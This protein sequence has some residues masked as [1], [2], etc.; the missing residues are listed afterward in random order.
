LHLNNLSDMICRSDPHILKHQ[1]IGIGQA[2]AVFSFDIPK[3]M[4]DAIAA[5]PKELNAIHGRIV[6]CAVAL[7][8]FIKAIDDL[9]F[10]FAPPPTS[11]RFIEA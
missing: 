2:R 7:F 1:R 11:H 5:Y 4:A 9:L 6:N 3:Q 10:Q 8:E